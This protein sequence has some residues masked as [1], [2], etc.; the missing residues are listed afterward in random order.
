MSQSTQ[1]DLSEAWEAYQQATTR[2]LAM[3]QEKA[4]SPELFEQAMLVNKLQREFAAAYDA[5]GGPK[6]GVRLVGGTDARR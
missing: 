6:S 3:Q 2:Y 4:R 1:K 5:P